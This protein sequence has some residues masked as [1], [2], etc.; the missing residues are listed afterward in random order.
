METPDE[1]ASCVERCRERVRT[2]R[3][4]VIKL[5]SR[6]L[7]QR[8]GRP[9]ARRI[10]GLVR[11]IVACRQEGREVVLVTSGAIGSGME[12]L[13]MK[14]RPTTLPELQMAAAVGQCR[15]MALYGRLF[16]AG[17]CKIGQVLLTHDDLK[18]R[19]RHLN[20]RNTMLAM[21]RAGIVPV[22]NEN[23]V[24]AVD[25]IKFGDNDLL[26]SLVVHLIQADLLILL[27]TA[28]GL[29]APS[30]ARGT[31]RVPFVESV[32]DEVLGLARG[33]GGELSTGGMA[34]KLQSARAAAQAGGC[35]VIADG[36]RA[37]AVSG[38]LAG[39]D[40]GTLIG[41]DNVRGALTGR[42][43]WIAYFNKP[44]GALVIDEG[45][46][47]AIQRKGKSLLPIGIKAVN[48]EFGAGSAVDIRGQD[49]A[50]IAR[51]LSAYSSEDVMKIMGRRT[52]DIKRILGDAAYE[53]AVHR[54]NMVV[55]G[56]NNEPAR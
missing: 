30:G 7:V 42:K 9:D 22:V 46:R 47:L 31:R 28:D 18:Q 23:D 37:G 38:I 3:R 2:A 24:V 48:G 40:I 32:T 43:R 26:A 10:R 41:P 33:K 35:V 12:H 45:A 27:T 8:T 29:R 20:A 56:G 1:S 53:E 39:H 17:R 16:A 14:R 25:E 13:G 50:V 6:V 51:G 55:S 36:R 54:D 52:D 4:I 34:S 11:D 49:G 44:Q 21:L 19:V 5:G 15:L